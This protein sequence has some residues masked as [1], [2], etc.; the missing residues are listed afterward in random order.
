MMQSCIKFTKEI[1]KGDAPRYMPHYKIYIWNI[2][3][4]EWGMNI[5]PREIWSEQFGLSEEKYE[6]STKVQRAVKIFDL[7]KEHFE[8]DVASDIEIIDGL[9]KYYVP[10]AKMRKNNEESYDRIFVDTRYIRS[11]EVLEKVYNDLVKNNVVRDMILYE[12]SASS[13]IGRYHHD[14]STELLVTEHDKWVAQVLDM[15]K[16]VSRTYY[17][18]L[19]TLNEIDYDSVMT[20]DIN[21]SYNLKNSNLYKR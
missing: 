7:Y 1:K 5:K 9:L 2:Y 14:S 18:Q 12:F 6:S 3:F 10:W 11:E 16:T 21:E 20:I 13:R 17:R 19:R 4:N 15:Y 8:T